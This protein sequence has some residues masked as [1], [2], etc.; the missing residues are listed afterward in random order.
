MLPDMRPLR[1]LNS[2]RINQCYDDRS[3]CVGREATHCRDNANDQRRMFE[4]FVR[5]A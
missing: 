1:R 5:D 3:M 2:Y 4:W